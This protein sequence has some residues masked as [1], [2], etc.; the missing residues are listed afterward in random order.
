MFVVSLN[1]RLSA[2][3]RLLIVAHK[4]DG[5]QTSQTTRSNETLIQVTRSLEYV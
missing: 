1:V 3:A 2:G 5:I 4:Y